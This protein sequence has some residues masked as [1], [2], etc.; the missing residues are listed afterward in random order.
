MNTVKINCCWHHCAACD[1]TDL[2]FWHLCLMPVRTV[3]L[4]AAQP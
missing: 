3:C 2:L 1:E 4:K